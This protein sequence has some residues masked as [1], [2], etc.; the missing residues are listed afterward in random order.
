M[1]LALLFLLTS[2]GGAIGKFGGIF[3]GSAMA[4]GTGMLLQFVF[5]AVCVVLSVIVAERLGMVR[6]HQRGWASGGGILGVGMATLVTL[7]T[8]SSPVALYLSPIMMGM[9][10]TL[11]SQIGK[12]AHERADLT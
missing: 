8:L 12:S 5:G 10:A 4:P 7:S 1:R 6:R 2:V 3:A 11:G 9:G